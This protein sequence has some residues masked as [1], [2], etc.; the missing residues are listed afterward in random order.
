MS[1]R[2]ELKF[3]DA[4]DE[5]SFYRKFQRLQARTD[6]LLR[7]VD[8]GDYFT[9][10]GEDA[11]FVAETVYRTTSVL[12]QSQGVN[13][14][15]MSTSVVGQ[16]LGL[17]L[18]ER[19]M[20]VEIYDRT[21]EPI[22]FASP[23]NIEQ[24]EDLIQGGTSG[25]DAN[26]GALVVVAIK[27]VN[28]TEGKNIGFCFVDTAGKEICVAEFV[29]NEV[30]S[31]LESLLIQI[32]AKEVL[33]QSSNTDDP[34]FVNMTGVVDRCGAVVTELKSSD[35]NNKD[36]EQDLTRLIGDELALS[37]GDISTSTA[38]LA[39]ASA[40]F[41]YL[42][43]LTDDSSFG[44]YKLKQHAL[45]HFMKLD[46]SA[47]KALN[48]FPT[49]GNQSGG[50]NTSIFGLLNHC[51]SAGGVRLLHQWIKQ[52]LVNVTE[53]QARHDLLQMLFEDTQM[54]TTLQD[55][56]LPSIP[57]VRRLNKKLLK[58]NSGNLEDVVRIYQFLLKVPDII[59]VLEGKQNEL[60]SEELKLL[61]ETTWTA[62]IR[63]LFAPLTKLQELVETTVDLDALDRHEFVIKPEYD[64]D[65]QAF[66]ARL[67]EIE[68]EIR[69]IHQSVADD[70]GLD[71]EKKLKL[72]LHSNHGWCMR[73]TR[74]EERA[75]RG[76]REYI[77]LQTV[78][79]G[80][81]FTTEQMRE[82]AA[83]SADIQQ[84]YSR[85]QSALVREI[86]GIA[87]TYAPVLEK[88]DMVLANLDVIVSFAHVSAY[89]PVPYVKPVMHAMGSVNG[90]TELTEARHP[91]VE[92]QDGVA[93]I[94]NDVKLSRNESEFL[95]ITGP[96][97]G[98][99]STFI[100][101][102]GCIALMAQIGCFVPA[103]T[104][105]LTVFDAVLARVGA[106]DS[107]LK[108][109]STFMVEMLETAS[110]LKTATADSL[111]IIDELG[112]GTSTYDGF[113]LAWAIAENIASKIHSF[114]LFATH[115]HELTKLSEQINTVKNLHVAAHVEDKSDDITL[116]YKV[117]P[118]VSDQSF[119]I[120]VAEVVGFPEKIV[121]MAKRKAAELDDHE[122]ESKRTRCT[123]EEITQGSELLKT[124]LKKW[125]SDVNL[126]E[127]S[128]DDAAGKLKK[129]VEEEYKDQI[130]A[131][132]F[133]KEALTL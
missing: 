37:V 17:C 102:L 58:K 56:L 53:I 3:S 12:K 85:Q 126:V 14:V 88:L 112:R 96:N 130:A 59:E 129:L 25:G 117:E 116:L 4:S 5:R 26:G 8:K 45:N 111:I 47:V 77:E 19:G 99:K 2:P 40:V 78:K 15:T 22:K 113:G 60:E 33:V 98:G 42:G 57:D 66:R 7:I 132:P 49:A 34:D 119:G 104:A 81:F 97:M 91:C 13:Y 41:Q 24:V 124:I 52:P 74:T 36:I 32:G 48:L 127:M 107:Q 62:Q 27:V 54:R 115:F 71:A 39:A 105:E 123:P 125:K 29:D 50:K 31:N 55:D 131:S 101:Q 46:S 121:N 110:I 9:A 92:A 95:V 23:G 68:E 109:V 28:K 10:L 106:G 133:A 65:L 122:E 11:A 70:L 61:V 79:A 118:G 69:S 6:S 86:V 82:I 90:K 51:K 21:W 114:T 108:G 38:G 94:A 1:S 72:E 87:A 44:T 89:A 76:K 100:R 18:F 83:E 80:V 84:K 30:Y 16:L 67:D 128:S 75:I 35:F 43:L 63:D 64:D 93:F 73:L 120:H 20:K 103:S